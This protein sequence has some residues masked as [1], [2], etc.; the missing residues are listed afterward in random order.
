MVQTGGSVLENVSVQMQQICQ[1][2]NA[3]L[4]EIHLNQIDQGTLMTKQVSI[5]QENVIQ[6]H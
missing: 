2:K 1:R 4:V 3:L 6:I 5:A